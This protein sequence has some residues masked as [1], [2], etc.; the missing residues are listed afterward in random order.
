MKIKVG[1]EAYRRTG[2]LVDGF[3]R[4]A[5]PSVQIAEIGIKERIMIITD[6]YTEVVNGETSDRSSLDQKALNDLNWA[7]DRLSRALEPIKARLVGAEL[8]KP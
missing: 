1:R 6:R 2:N 8:E 5:G 4:T 7:I 3:A